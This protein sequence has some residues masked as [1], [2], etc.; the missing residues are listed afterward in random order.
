ML[1]GHG[2]ESRLDALVF[3]GY[4][5][6][7]EGVMVHGE[8]LVADGEHKSGAAT[9]AAFRAAVAALGVKR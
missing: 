1:T 3:S 9:R 8:W 2:D 4:R 6:P 5:L 7:I